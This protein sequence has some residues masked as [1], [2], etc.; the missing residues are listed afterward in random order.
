MYFRVLRIRL[1]ALV[2]TRVRNGELTERRLARLSGISQPHIHN[3]LK[4]DRILST[5]VA[6]EII[7]ALDITLAE[8]L[9]PGDLLWRPSRGTVDGLTA[10]ADPNA[11]SQSRAGF[12]QDAWSQKLDT[13]APEEEVREHGEL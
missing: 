5:K 12:A 1:L 13:E 3:V 9:E 2:R 6:D 11:V 7:R 10:E 8:L 4:G